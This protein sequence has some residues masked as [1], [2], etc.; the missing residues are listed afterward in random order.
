MKYCTRCV[1]PANHPLNLT[2]DI[3]GVC[4]GCRVHEEKDMLDW[5]ERLAK[6]EKIFGQFR[7]RSR[8]AYD[9]IVPVSGAQDSYFIVHVVKNIFNMH[10]LL[11]SYNKQY[12]TGTGIRNLAYLQSVFG[13][14]L[15]S[16]T[17]NPEKVKR[18]TR[19]S[20]QQCGSMYWHCLAGTTVFPVRTAIDLKVPLIVW[21][22]HQGGDQVGM[23][24]HLDEVEMTRKYRK[25]H[26][27]MGIE[28]EDLVRNGSELT[29]SEM[30]PFLYPHDKELE[31]VGVR[32]IYLS[33][34]VRWD[35]KAQ[36]ESMIDR[37]DYEATR[38]QRTFDTY[39][40]VDCVHYS[41]LH[42]YIKFLK[43]GYGKVSDHA[44][45]EIRLKR[46]TREE[47]IASV[48]NYESVQPTDVT[49][50]CEWL[51]VG[52]RELFEHVDSF[53][54]PQIWHQTNAGCWE[55][56]D[57]VTNHVDD[58]GVEEVRLPYNSDCE[59]RL[60]PPREVSQDVE[61]GYAH[62]GRAC[63]DTG[64][65]PQLIQKFPTERADADLVPNELLPEMRSA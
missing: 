18:V 34:Y 59:F 17:V 39:S 44:S 47:G 38:Q 36:H 43:W 35:S 22:A 6:L 24:S 16:C 20:L 37:F 29:L 49:Q 60:S 31:S 41:G 13:C 10:P 23:F 19:E 15:I 1:Y 50:F 57:S 25:E 21:G 63:V 65:L 58:S 11:V 52:E 27:L 32:G 64:Y 28:A 48:R 62:I 14:D 54:D 42:D 8:T 45:R 7:A 53:R 5:E 33:N 30:Q 40:D 55:L 4:S 12:N 51:D 9:C 3:Q 2:F 61:G 26:D 46:M 56:R